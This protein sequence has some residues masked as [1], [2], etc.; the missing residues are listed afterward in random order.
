MDF[1]KFHMWG[2][3]YNYFTHSDFDENYTPVADILHYE[4]SLLL[5]FVIETDCVVCEVWAEAKE[6]VDQNVTIEND[7]FQISPFI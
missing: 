7:W 3:Y 6:T 4:I 1:L 2:F 5:V